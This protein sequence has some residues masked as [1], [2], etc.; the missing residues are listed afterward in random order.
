[1]SDELPAHPPTFVDYEGAMVNSPNEFLEAVQAAEP[2]NA[3][4]PEHHFVSD[5]T[6]LRIMSFNIHF[7]SSAHQT[8][9]NEEGIYQDMAK[10]QPDLVVFQEITST[11]HES[12]QI[13]RFDLRMSQLGYVH[14]IRVFSGERFLE[15]GNA[16]YSKYPFTAQHS[17]QFTSRRR[18][19]IAVTVEPVPGLSFEIYGTHL[20]VISASQRL[21]QI[22]EL[23]ADAELSSRPFQLILGDFN[24][25]YS[26]PVLAMSRSHGFS[27]VFDALHDPRGR[28]NFTCWTGTT[29]DFILVSE[30]LQDSGRIK[31]AYVGYTPTSDHLPVIVDLDLTPKP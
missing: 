6:S 12:E 23:L 9:N 15:L 31:G 24:S 8:R 30:G 27:D 18:C 7:F 22:T 4:I 21:D 13:R 10:F 14:K 17:K 3:S 26:S 1:M 19:M 5:P 25:W 11:I 20:E 2:L 29:I 28:P 16:V